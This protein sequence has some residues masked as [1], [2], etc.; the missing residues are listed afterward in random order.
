M[1]ISWKSPKIFLFREDL[2]FKV[3]EIEK[4]YVGNQLLIDYRY[5][6]LASIY[7]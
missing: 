5:V 1:I 6:I 4:D 2:N 7:V 3:R